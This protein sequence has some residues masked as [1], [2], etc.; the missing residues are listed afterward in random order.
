M[1]EKQKLIIRSAVERAAEARRLL[2]PDPGDVIMAM[3][4]GWAMFCV[5]LFTGGKG[6]LAQVAKLAKARAIKDIIMNVDAGALVFVIIGGAVL[7]IGLVVFCYSYRKLFYGMMLFGAF[8]SSA[9]WKPLHDV[10]FLMKYLTILFIACYAG[11]FIFKN[12]WRLV[13]TPY[14]R[15][16]LFYVV[17]VGVICLTLGGKTSDIWY[18]GTD[19][20]L[21][22]G[23]AA[24][25][26][27]YIET[28]DQ[29]A[30]FNSILLWTA[31]PVILIT[32]TA[33]VL[34]DGYLISG[35]FTGF[36]NRATGFGTLFAPFVLVIFWKAM[37]KE[38][39]LQKNLFMALA[40]LGFGLLV[41][42]GTRSALLALF[43]C[44]FILWRVLRTKIFIYMFL[45]VAAGITSQ[46]VGGGMDQDSLEK[47]TARFQLEEEST[48]GRFEIW[49]RNAELVIASPVYGHSPSGRNRFGKNTITADFL[50]K[51]TGRDVKTIATH[52][53]YLGM[54][55]KFGFVG[56]A[57]LLTLII[58]PFNRARKLIFSD[59]LPREEK[60]V[61]LLPFTLAA[62]LIIMVFF[63]DAVSAQGRG[64][65]QGML[66]FTLLFLLNKMG[67]K[68]EEKYL[69]KEGS[70]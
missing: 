46:I 9:S 19:V 39:G 42:S 70:E 48:A 53:A 11:L 35:R 62:L 37:S 64:T 15:V 28:T 67:I 32:A 7:V 47:F 51:I 22:I 54:L 2:M 68:H 8:Y 6:M 55:V 16:M 12:F 59:L 3:V 69:N 24:G 5:M 40:M 36:T 61:F 13:E 65:V 23:L 34:A 31:V 17:W 30:E 66:L 41:W 33:P 20:A 57:I 49:S 14:V 38:D 63:E 43:I 27:N 56:L 45:I 29:L 4:F 21:L 10:A 52:N 50:E 60:V 44:I 25:W 1:A 26:W 58:R 18:A